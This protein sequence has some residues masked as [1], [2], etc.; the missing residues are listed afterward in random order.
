MSEI[1]KRPGGPLE[2]SPLK[3]GDNFYDPEHP[4]KFGVDESGNEKY[5]GGK[6]IS[7]DE[8]H[9][10]MFWRHHKVPGLHETMI[11]SVRSWIDS[12]TFRAFVSGEQTDK[13]FELDQKSKEQLSAYRILAGELGY[14]IG[15]YTF[16]EKSGLVTAT[17]V[18]T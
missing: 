4:P 17:I 12:G 5:E 2:E 7:K 16:H 18:K 8:A 3:I 6:I 13:G 1:P 11:E 14:T 15:S 10:I 9:S